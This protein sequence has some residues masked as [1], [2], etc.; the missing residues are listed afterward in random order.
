M[1]GKIS[2]NRAAVGQAKA[3]ERAKKKSRGTGTSLAKSAYAAPVSNQDPTAE[4]N[5]IENLS[6]SPSPVATKISNTAYT[7]PTRQT[8]AI[9]VAAGG[10]KRELA[11]IGTMAL[12]V[13][14]LLVVLRL[15]SD[16][17][18]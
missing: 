4:A 10:L 9:V 14:T 16:L 6:D 3:K 13:S 17:G 5:A 1:A 12:V 2:K 18:S 15:Y 8:T 7:R 11:L